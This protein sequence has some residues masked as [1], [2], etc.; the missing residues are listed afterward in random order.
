M[1]LN[2]SSDEVANYLHCLGVLEE[3]AASLYMILAEK[4]EWPLVRSIVLRIAFD[5]EKHSAVLNGIVQSISTLKKPG[6]CTKNLKQALDSVSAMSK[7]IAR[8]GKITEVDFASI[9]GQLNALESVLGE[10]YAVIVDLETLRLIAGTLSEIY[11]ID[12]GNIGNM[13]LD[14]IR[15]EDTHML[16]IAEIR[17]L[18]LATREK[19]DTTPLVKY[20]HPDA[21]AK[22]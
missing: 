4:I 10:E 20:Q 16:L 22:F 3:R 19:I 9:E 5:A 15:D 11:A 17:R 7:E 18:F 1:K 2:K 13:F 21:W 8:K 12:I 14:I 6:S